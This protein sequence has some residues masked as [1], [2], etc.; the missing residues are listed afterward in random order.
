PQVRAFDI[1]HCDVMDLVDPSHR[2]DVHD[3]GVIELG[4]GHR[5][6]LEPVQIS[7]SAQV[8][9]A[10][11][12]QG[13][14]TVQADLPGEVDLTHAPAAQQPLDLEV[15]ECQ[16]GQIS[17]RDALAVDHPGEGILFVG[18]APINL[19]H[20][21]DPAAS[22]WRTRGDAATDLRPRAETIVYGNRG[23]SAK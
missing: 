7:G 17:E 21:P 18:E 16:A 1:L 15:A 9:G 19:A 3:V 6:G 14:R 10:Q 22:K 5:L 12:L 13:D 2:V 4:D 23:G 11:H 20:G 8:I